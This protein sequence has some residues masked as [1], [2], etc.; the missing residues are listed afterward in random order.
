M[1]LPK[2]WIDGCGTSLNDVGVANV[3][4]PLILRVPKKGSIIL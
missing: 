4:R 2:M 1:E 3:R